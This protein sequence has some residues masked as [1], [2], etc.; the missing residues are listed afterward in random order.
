MSI[1]TDPATTPDGGTTWEPRGHPVRWA[2]GVVTLIG[3]AL[4][5]SIWF[6]ALTPRIDVQASTWSS[7]PAG[8]N[9]ATL[10]LEVENEAHASARL[11]GAGA[12]LP[13]LELTGTEVG[14]GERLGGGNTT[15]LAPG[16]T[17]SVTLRYRVTDCA[18]LPSE[19]PSIQVVLRTP[20]GLTRTVSD[21]NV[22]GDLVGGDQP[23]RWTEDLLPRC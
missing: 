11:V 8:E 17:V 3:S 15:V 14:S 1:V 22:A 5:A 7:E 13:G 6:G 4:L 12:S 10:V 19:P 21:G 16:E 9:G 20:L 18:A 2:V 23:T